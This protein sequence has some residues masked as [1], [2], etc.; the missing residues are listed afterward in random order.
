MVVIGDGES[1]QA[2]WGLLLALRSEHPLLVDAACGTELRTLAGERDLPPYAR[3]GAGR[4][5]LCG[6]DHAPRRVTLPLP[7]E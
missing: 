5:W 4:A 3:P 6:A 2:H 7:T 1:W